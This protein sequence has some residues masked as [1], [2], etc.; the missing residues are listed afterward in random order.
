MIPEGLKLS[1]E[2][3]LSFKQDSRIKN[4]VSIVIFKLW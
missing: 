2:K 1:Q 3:I 4:F